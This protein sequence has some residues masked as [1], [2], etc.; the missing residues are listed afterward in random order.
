MNDII[1]Q[2]PT[3]VNRTYRGGKL[4]REFL[5]D[6]NAVDNFEPEDW[7]SSFVEAKNKNYIKNEGISRV[8]TPNGEK[9]ITDVINADCFGAGRKDSGVLIK[10]LDASERLGIQV[11]PTKNY[12]RKVFCSEYGKTECWHVLGTRNDEKNKAVVYLGFKQGITKEIWK[13]L[14]DKQDVDGMLSYMHKFEV[15]KGDTILVTGG[16]PHAIGSGCFLLE[17]QEPSD[18]TMRAETVTVAGEVLTAKQIHY[19]VGIENML[20]CFEYIGRS[21]KDTYDLFFL[22]PRKGLQ[23]EEVLVS[24]DDTKC[25]ALK[26]ATDYSASESSFVT[27]VAI[28]GGGILYSDKERYN[29][30]AGDRFFIKANVR[31]TVKNANVL[32]CYPPK[33]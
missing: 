30:V 20:N 4:L 27:V 21:Y 7:I 6:S 18:Y 16:T 24:Y 13:E 29:L 26:K 14:F 19:G 32:I 8:I 23:S 28:N 31:F 12:A 10:F 25:F 2:K 11:H 1:K 15:K 9:F 22:K 33:I 17:I 3:F 5:G